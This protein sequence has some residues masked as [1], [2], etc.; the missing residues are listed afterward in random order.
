MIRL[1]LTARGIALAGILVAACRDAPTT[2]PT[3]GPLSSI[4]GEELDL[5]DEVP[6]PARITYAYTQV[7]FYDGSLGGE[8]VAEIGAGMRYIGNHAT[9]ATSYRITGEGINATDK[10]PNEQKTIY[11]PWL[12]KRWDENY[13]IP[14]NRN[15][16]LLIEADTQHMARW[17]VSVRGFPEWESNRDT[18]FTLAT[19]LQVQPCEPEPPPDGGGGN[20]GWSG[21]WITIETCY[22]WAHYFNGVLVDIELRYCEYDTVPVADQ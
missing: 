16:G 22:Y 18:R 6:G 21:G 14:T 12:E 4:S 10:I 13:Q 1:L 11:V 19:P 15:C 9:M 17:S 3:P 5:V 20:G 2:V 8:P 7:G